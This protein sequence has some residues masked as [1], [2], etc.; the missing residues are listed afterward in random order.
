MK[1]LIY[2]I[3]L[4][5]K[6]GAALLWLLLNMTSLNAQ[7]LINEFAA[8][9][10]NTIAD[11]EF[12]NYSD[13]IELHNIDSQAWNLK[14]F[15]LTDNM[16]DPNKWQITMDTILEPNGFIIIWADGK[17]T[18]LHTSYKISAI[19]EEIALYSPGSRLIDSISF[20]NQI[21]DVSFGRLP[22]DKST[23]AFF[24]EPSPGTANST[25]PFS[26][27]VFN[28]PE[29]SKRGGFYSGSQSISIKTDF[30][31]IIRYTADGS[32]PQSTSPSYTL[33]I[34]ISETTILRARIFKEGK[35]PGPTV[36]QSYF[37]NENSAEEAL[38]LVSISTD[39]A[40]FW[41]P[42]KGIY[43]QDFKPSWE[44]PINIELFEN[45]GM[46]RASF[47]QMAGVKINGLYSWQL[48]QKMLGVYFKKA[49]GS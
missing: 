36:T 42:E 4:F 33:P 49:Y 5:T 13:W 20:S 39:P 37:I 46:D 29:F 22:E 27:I 28:T 31:G 44:I 8:S 45:N 6:I 11:P 14:N 35:V 43:V 18:G 15:Y 9:N 47:N 34:E 3:T 17:N 12:N 19:G 16:N 21:S 26:D 2:H 38:P 25:D 48:P 30:G 40:N 1:N 41:D 23:W 32:E 24:S 7:I 10:S